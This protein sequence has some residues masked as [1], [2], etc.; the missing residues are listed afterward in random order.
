MP[1][2]VITRDWVQKTVAPSNGDIAASLWL[3]GTSTTTKEETPVRLHVPDKWG[4]K[5]GAKMAHAAGGACM[6]QQQQS[7]W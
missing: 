1:Q 5:R 4:G 7:C 3:S 6:T 2:L